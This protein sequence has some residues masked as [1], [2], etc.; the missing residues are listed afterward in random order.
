EALRAALAAGA[1]VAARTG[2]KRRTALQAAADAGHADLVAALLDAGAA[3]DARD[4]CG[5][6]ALW[7]AAGR[8]HLAVVRL[9]PRCGAD[10]GGRD[11][12]AEQ[13]PLMQAVLADRAEVVAS[14]RA[15]GA[16]PQATDVD[17]LSADDYARHQD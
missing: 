1:D 10:V 4:E 16:D 6:T 9:L 11:F 2:D 8:G 5:R 3:I 14:L 15:A 17:G 13:T 12:E 7:R